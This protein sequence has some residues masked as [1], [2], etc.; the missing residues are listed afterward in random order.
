MVALTHGKAGLSFNKAQVITMLSTHLVHLIE[1]HAE[2]LFRG[3]ISDLH[4]NKLT[5]S[6]HRID[7]E[8]LRT[9][10]YDVYRHLGPWLAHTTEDRIEA[11]FTALGHKRSAEGIPLS[12]VIFTLV[13]AKDHLRAFIRTRGLMDSRVELYQEQEF[14]RLVGR[15]FDRAIYYTVRGYEREP[16]HGL[17]AAD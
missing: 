15:F 8:S 7:H 14:Q 5:P 11:V 12:E 13:L 3:L 1:D 10:L 6:Y 16:T 17:K 9:R 4:Q 2:E